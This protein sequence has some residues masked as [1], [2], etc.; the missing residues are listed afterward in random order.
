MKTKDDLPH[1][2]D[3][4]LQAVLDYLWEN[5][6]EDF[7]INPQRGHIFL[8]LRRLASFVGYDGGSSNG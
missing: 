6:M 3:H 5:E 2:V 8:A 4:A 1:D 7:E